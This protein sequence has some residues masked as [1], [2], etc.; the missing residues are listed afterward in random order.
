MDRI[1]KYEDCRGD[2]E[3]NHFDQSFDTIHMFVP[4][5]KTPQVMQ[6]SVCRKELL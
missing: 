1:I 2:A 4:N 3:K 6:Q 5:V